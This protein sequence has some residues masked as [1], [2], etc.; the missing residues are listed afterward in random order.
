MDKI[1]IEILKFIQKEFPVDERPYRRIS[2]H[3]GIDERDVAERIINLHREG[4]IKKIIPKFSME[5]YE[6]YERALVAMNIK[7]N[8]IDYARKYINSFENVTHNYLRDHHYNIWFTV[9]GKNYEE[10]KSQ[11]ENIAEKLNVRDYII[12]KTLKAIKLDTEF[13]VEI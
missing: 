9:S 3:I 5:S 7:E 11:V 6:K 10:I 1:D 4:Y 13:G 12:L 2:E 8:D